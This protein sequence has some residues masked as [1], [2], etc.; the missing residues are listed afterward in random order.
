MSGTTGMGMPSSSLELELSSELED[1]SEE[2]PC[3]EGDTGDK[4]IGTPEMREVKRSQ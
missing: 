3:L 1:S 2:E 4:G